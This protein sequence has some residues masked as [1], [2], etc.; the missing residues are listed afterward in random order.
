M[1][2]EAMEITNEKVEETFE[3]SDYKGIK[4]MPYVIG[5][6]T[7]EKLGTIG[8]S[9]NLLVYLTTVFNM[10]SLA[11]VN[12]INV[13]NG[14]CNFG[15]LFGAFL[16]DTY[17]GRYNVIGFASISSLVTLG[18]IERFDN[19]EAVIGDPPLD[20]TVE[21]WIVDHLISFENERFA[22]FEAKA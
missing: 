6:E 17:F 12:L 14:T 5:N 11:A 4:A 18:E 3:E 13:F 20:E 15:T 7:F 16:S 8:T 21:R 19:D 22:C 9:A 10:K 2:V 1:E